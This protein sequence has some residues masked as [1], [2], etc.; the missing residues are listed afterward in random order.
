VR[1]A[2]LI[3]CLLALTACHRHGNELR[4]RV[5]YSGQNPAT[6]KIQQAERE[7]SFT[8]PRLRNTKPFVITSGV[9]ADPAAL[10]ADKT[11]SQN[12]DL[13]I[14][15]SAA[16]LPDVPD[17]RKAMGDSFSVCQQSVA[18]IPEWAS[19]ERREG[20]ARFLQY[21]STHCR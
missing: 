21:L 20:A 1:R 5:L 15:K 3:S 4:V 19:D 9:V 14:L 7:F 2:L 16:E 6:P 18:Y 12:L 13:F 17:L 11:R 10:I 8:D